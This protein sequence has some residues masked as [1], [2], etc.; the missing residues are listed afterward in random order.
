MVLHKLIF[1]FYVLFG[2]IASILKFT[3]NFMVVKILTLFS[4]KK[5]V[6]INTNL[7][8]SYK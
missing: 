7:N 3:F 2:N 1:K 6:Q 8:V 4:L 5:V